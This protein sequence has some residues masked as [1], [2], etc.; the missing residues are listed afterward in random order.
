MIYAGIL[1]GGKGKRMGYTEM[2]KQFLELAGKPIIIHTLEKF[3]L[4][5]QIDKIYIGCIADWTGHTADLVDKYIGWTDKIEVCEGGKDRNG[6][7]MNIITAVREQFGIN[8]DDILITHDAVRPFVTHR[9]I[10]E[11]I[12]AA[13]KYGICDTVIPATDTIC[14][15]NDG[16]FLKEIPW[17]ND[18]YQGQTPQSFNINLLLKHFET[19]TEEEKATLWLA[20]KLCVRRGAMLYWGAGVVKK[21]KT[22]TP[23]DLSV[24]NAI[25]KGEVK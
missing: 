8:D 3:L 21:K 18:M 23:Y 6:T 24:A 19:L 13:K 22:T 17:R 12:A 5:P 10:D 2:P 9:M 20:L 11:N 16:Q 4:N 14:V 25:V 7:I 15:S 1:A